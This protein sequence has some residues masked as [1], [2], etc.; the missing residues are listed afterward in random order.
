MPCRPEVIAGLEVGQYPIL[1]NMVFTVWL[2]PSLVVLTGESYLRADE[3]SLEG[4]ST[5]APS[6]TETR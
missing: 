5:L 6:K 3:K 4:K 1:D 2:E